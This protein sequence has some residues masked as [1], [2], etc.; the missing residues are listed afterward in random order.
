MDLLKTGKFIQEQRKAKNL[1]QIQLAEKINVSEKTISKWECG[2]G[3]PDTSL[4][5]PLCEVLAIS[6]NELLSGKKLETSEEYK[7]QAEEN[8]VE[9]KSQQEKST[10]HLLNCEWVIIWLGMALL[11]GSC[12]I[13]A[14]VN[15]LDVWRFVIIGFGI[16]NC[17]FAIVASMIIETKV[18]FY[19]CAKC[20]H[21]YV[22][23]YKQTVWS[24]HFG[25]TRF[26]KC[27]KC[28]KRS[29]NKKTINDK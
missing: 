24:M 23:S 25:R 21:R 26:I 2:N 15:M 20:K 16:L 10:K 28:G 13:A 22:P 4:I 9:L 11:L 18:G 5:L 3:F 17:V 8:L 27:P 29:W 12:L 6:A 19:E 7:N 14:Y 1:T